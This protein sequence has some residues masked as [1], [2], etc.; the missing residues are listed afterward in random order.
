[1]DSVLNS[2]ISVTS[3]SAHGFSAAQLM[4]VIRFKVDMFAPYS[5][6]GSL[7]C[8]RIIWPGTRSL[9]IS[10]PP[11]SL[12]WQFRTTCNKGLLDSTCGKSFLWCTQVFVKFSL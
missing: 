9:R 7:S 11:W 1:M 2:L 10:A 5:H 12:T 8:L 3:G 6:A 4:D